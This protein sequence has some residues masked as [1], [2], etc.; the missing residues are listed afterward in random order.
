MNDENCQEA[1]ESMPSFIGVKIINA[2]PQPCPRDRHMSKAGAPGYMVQYEDG[3][4]SWSPA[5]AFE[6]AYRKTNSMNFGLALEAM[7]KGK[8]VARTGWNGKGMFVYLVEG[9]TVPVENLRGNCA[10]A[11]AASTNTA[12]V[13]DICGHIDMKAADGSIVVGWLASQT[14]MLAD[15]WQIVEAV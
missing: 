10:K 12:P 2:C 5:A 9:T 6:A 8:F 3:Y 4:T 14:D 7:R 11:I 13:Q 1:P 15:D